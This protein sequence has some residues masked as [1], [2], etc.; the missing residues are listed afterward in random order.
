MREFFMKTERI[1]FSKWNHADLNLAKELWGEAEVTRFICATGKFTNKDIYR[2]FGRR[3]FINN[4]E[5]HYSILA[6]YLNF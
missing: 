2:S 4:K 5:F 6:E 1:G 3:M